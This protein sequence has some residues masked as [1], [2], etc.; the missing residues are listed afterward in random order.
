MKEKKYYIAFDRYEQ[1]TMIYALNEMRNR[2]IE[3]DRYT[4]AVDELIIKIC[5]AKTKNFKII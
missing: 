3:E 2:L 1:G 5:N 4:D